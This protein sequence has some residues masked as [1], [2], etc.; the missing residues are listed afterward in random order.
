MKHPLL[1]PLFV[2]TALAAQAQK[3]TVT[4]RVLSTAGEAQPGAT[5]LERGTTN[6]TATGANGEFTL[7]VPTDGTLVI[8]A[9]GFAA[10]TIA[11]QGRPRLDVRLAAA[12]TDLSDVVVTGSRA[13]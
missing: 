9:I 10:Q 8:S 1:V 6:G 3:I 11:V 5:V 4:G 12:A 7:S 13:T 2:A